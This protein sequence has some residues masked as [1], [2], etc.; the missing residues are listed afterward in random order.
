MQ[1]TMIRPGPSTRCVRR[2]LAAS[3][4]LLLF[5]A[6]PAEAQAEPGVAAESAEAAALRARIE[7]NPDDIA[8]R[9][10]LGDLLFREGDALGSMRVQNPGRTPDA[11][12]AGELR[13]AARVYAEV[14]E[15]DAARRALKAAIDLA[16]GDASL[17]EDLAALYQYQRRG[18]QAPPGGA[19]TGPETKAQPRGAPVPLAGSAEPEPLPVQTLSGAAAIGLLVLLLAR[20][21]LRGKGDLA[22][23]IETAADGRGVFSVRLSHKRERGRAGAAAGTPESRAS[24]QLEHN[25]IARETHFR[26][27]PARRY[28]VTIEGQVEGP[29]SEVQAI[30]R[31]CEVVVEKGRTT[32]VQFDLRPQACP[33]DV[34]V[35]ASGEPVGEARVALGGDPTSVRLAKRGTLR[36]HLD[37]G[38]YSILVGVADR[39]AERTLDVPSFD[40]MTVSID[41]DLPADLEGGASLAF[42]GCETAVEPFLRGDLSVA[43]AALERGGQKAQADLLLARFHQH[44]GATADAA[45]RFEAAGRLLEAAELWAEQGDFERAASLFERGNDPARAA[46]MYNASGDLIR[47]GRSYEDAGD[48]EAAI[49][50]YR[51]SDAPRLLDA[52]EKNGQSFEAGQLAL[53]QG[54]PSRAV[55]NFQH[56]DPRDPDYFRACRILATTFTEQGKLELAVQKADEAITFSRPDETSPDTFVWYGDLLASAGR[57]DRA[58]EVFE[59]LSQR[60]PDHPGVDTRIDEIRKQIS[61]RRQDS[62]ATEALPRAFDDASRYEI[63]RE[64][65]SGGMGIVYH[66]RDR[67]LG[68]DVALKRLPDNLKDHPRAVDLFL[69]EARASAALNHPNIVTVHDVDQEGGL[70]FIT[71]ELLVG[72][73]LSQLVARHGRLQALDVIRIGSQIAAGLGFAHQQGIIHRDIKSANL[74]LTDDRIVKVMDFGLAKMIEE[75]R[76]STTVVGGTPYYMAPEQASGENVDA[77]ADIYAFGVTLFEL[78]TAHRP[79]EEGD[80]TWHHRNTPAPDPR[81][82]GAEVPEGLAALVLEMMSKAP[83]DRPSQAES[84]GRRLAQLGRSLQRGGSAGQA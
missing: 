50:C 35:C 65:G 49:V 38:T 41:L 14:A 36:L 6:P 69:R 18:T 29:A 46:E 32:P 20:R 15:W 43:A 72:Q 77:R 53:D 45:S 31:D 48:F 1:Q 57:P 4:W 52:L 33:V 9:R 21:A 83:E 71:M 12:W 13:N 61:R 63:V 44:H 3:L 58:L 84:V 51:E 64:V 25:L 30:R 37:P 16:P 74:F 78:A 47:A 40:P 19:S 81:S 24:S 42:E 28:W 55:R 76:R 82:L 62:A 5:A 7:E 56:V 34:Q 10:E 67:R 60:S 8:A 17:Y 54:D 79:F 59:E 2:A 80:V 73:T 11:G 22:V 66:A 75:V 68:R 23:S 26:A 70:Y 27:I 39:A